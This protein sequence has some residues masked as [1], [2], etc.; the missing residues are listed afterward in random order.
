MGEHRKM[1]R[2]ERTDHKPFG[3]LVTGGVS[4]R[5]RVPGNWHARFCSRGGGSDSL[6]YCNPDRGPRAVLSECEKLRSG[7]GG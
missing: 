7:R 5:S 2:C 4:L 6:A 3:V 1:R